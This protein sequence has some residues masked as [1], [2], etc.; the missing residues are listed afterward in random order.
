M[1]HRGEVVNTRKGTVRI[2]PE[3]GGR[4]PVLMN[5]G[6]PYQVTI[7]D[8]ANSNVDMTPEQYNNLLITPDE[9][10]NLTPEQKAVIEQKMIAAEADQGVIDRGQAATGI[11]PLSAEDQLRSAAIARDA[12]RLSNIYQSGQVTPQIDPATGEPI[13]ITGEELALAEAGRNRTSS[14]LP[15]SFDQISALGQPNLNL[16][17][18][19]QPPANY[20][21]SQL[22]PSQ[23]EFIK[24]KEEGELG[25]AQ[26]TGV[27][28]DVFR[29]G[30]DPN[31]ETV[32]SLDVI[33]DPE[34]VQ[35]RAES[36]A[37]IDGALALQGDPTEEKAY[38]EVLKALSSML[39]KPEEK[40]EGK[41]AAFLDLIQQE[42][43]MRFAGAVTTAAAGTGRDLK[44]YTEYMDARSER[45]LKAA[46]ENREALQAKAT[47]GLKEQENKLAF[48][49][50]M[51][52]AETAVPGITDTPAFK[53]QMLKYGI[54]PNLVDFKGPQYKLNPDTLQI[55]SVP[56]GTEGATSSIKVVELSQKAGL[57]RKKELTN[58]TY[59]K[60]T[61]E[62]FKTQGIEL[63]QDQMDDMTKV[64]IGVKDPE[65]ADQYTMRVTEAG[66]VVVA[67]SATG[68]LKIHKNIINP[69]GSALSI[70]QMSASDAETF[71]LVQQGMLDVRRLQAMVR[72]AGIRGIVGETAILNAYPEAQALMTQIQDKIGRIRSGG[73]ITQDEEGSFKV[74][75]ATTLN[76]LFLGDTQATIT[77]LSDIDNE[78]LTIASAMRPKWNFHS[79]AIV[80]R[81]DKAVWNESSF[82]NTGLSM[83][84]E[85]KNSTGP[86]NVKG[87][88]SRK[89]IRM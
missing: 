32:G 88:G 79:D 69:Y 14:A 66:D 64:L 40:P 78:F 12:D 17:G 1:P 86:G 18:A 16:L 44:Q 50:Y 41:L 80:A 70:G 4:T 74:M 87:K 89:T 55:M 19:P 13:M 29:L 11:V 59:I 84:K 37:A 5:E 48:M 6:Q 31:A 42:D 36:E 85:G 52:E 10:E 21:P 67:N 56:Y 63:T 62:F 15:L 26:G 51:H 75:M 54:N 47:L 68:Q 82:G 83:S 43:F 60:D 34:V 22:E 20:Q 65:K 8:Y 73:A 33:I 38:T 57:A 28:H 24:A 49:S 7:P 23:E 81:R 39:D 76:Q 45:T 27:K 53:A 58:I 35:N 72:Q 71:A 77:A 46:K 3:T 30:F 61:F 9:F 2:N 25:F